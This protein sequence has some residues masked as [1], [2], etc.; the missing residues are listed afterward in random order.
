MG[1][2]SNDPATDTRTPW[3]NAGPLPHTAD[4]GGRME[5]VCSLLSL[6]FK[7]LGLL[8]V[9]SKPRLPYLLQDKRSIVLAHRMVMRIN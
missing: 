9:F 5:F 3:S 7:T 2:A 1:G 8:L 6:T 4:V